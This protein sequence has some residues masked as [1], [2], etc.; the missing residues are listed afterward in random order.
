M[1]I[2]VKSLG[3]DTTITVLVWW[4][5]EGP[6]GN[7][8]ERFTW[9]GVTLKKELLVP[10]HMTIKQTRVLAVYAFI[11]QTY[12]E[13]FRHDTRPSNRAA[14]VSLYLAAIEGRGVL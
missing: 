5:A 4:T 2:F 7:E 6:E 12:I 13:T 1:A 3:N 11:T 9:L 14:M 10:F 8:E